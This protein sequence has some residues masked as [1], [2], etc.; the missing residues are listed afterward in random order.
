MD[1]PNGV[2][3]ELVALGAHQCCCLSELANNMQRQEVW[4]ID[5]LVETE[6]VGLIVVWPF[7]ELAHLGHHSPRQVAGCR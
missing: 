2:C 3:D 1:L 5:H 4:F 7:N 6:R